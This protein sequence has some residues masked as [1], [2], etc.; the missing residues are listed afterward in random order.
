[1]KQ[2]AGELRGII[3]QCISARIS[4]YICDNFIGQVPYMALDLTALPFYWRAE[5]ADDVCMKQIN[6][7]FCSVR[8]STGTVQFHSELIKLAVNHKP[9][10]FFQ[11]LI[12]TCLL[13]KLIF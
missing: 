2:S 9:F 6:I 8:Y 4:Q 5:T 10:F 12:L 1:M 13:S 11:L 7:F 3:H